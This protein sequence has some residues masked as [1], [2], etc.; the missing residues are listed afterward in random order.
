MDKIPQILKILNNTTVVI[1]LGSRDDITIHDSF[2]ILDKHT[3]LLIDPTTKE[4]LG[5]IEKIKEKV[6]VK[7]VHEKF[8]ICVSKYT[9]VEYHDPVMETLMKPFDPIT[10]RK[11][12]SKRVIGNDMSVDDKEVSPIYT[13]ETIHIGDKVRKVKK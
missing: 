6:F 5:N 13:H 7:E 2:D 3:I 12:S 1:N 11:K 10:N 8:C 4:I 9:K